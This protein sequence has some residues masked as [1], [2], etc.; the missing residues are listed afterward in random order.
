MD[1]SRLPL[2]PLDFAA[3]AWFAVSAF[4]FQYLCRVGPIG[5]H[6]IT[7]AVQLQRE[8]WMSNMSRRDNRVLDTI[9]LGSLSQGN[10][11]FA[12]TSVIAIGGL[13]ALVGSGDKFQAFVE[14]MPFVQ[15]S[16]A[17]VF[18][19]KILFM[20]GIAI[21]AFFKFAWAFRLS[22]YVAIMIGSTP[23]LAP[24]GSNRAEC[25]LHAARAARL[26][27]IAGEHA[28]SGLRSFYYAIAALAWFIG[29]LAF[30]VA[31]TWVLMTLIRRE[32]MSR[33]LRV[34]SGAW[35]PDHHAAP[36]AAPPSQ[37]D[38]R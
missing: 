20:M 19:G 26:I 13:A 1:F 33:S 17:D 15:S 3:L 29:P 30:I 21:Y 28:N 35:F 7:T 14:R 6:S 27:G 22:H 32:Y 9:L 23:L 37:T 18:D 12:S 38:R 5:R 36:P 24:D 10:A 8:Q 25:D 16:S 34:L 31:T 4:A 2:T 11:F